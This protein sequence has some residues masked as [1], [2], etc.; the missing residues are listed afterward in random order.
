MKCAEAV[1]QEHQ[2][3]CV[4]RIGWPVGKG[5]QQQAEHS[6]DQQRPN[7]NDEG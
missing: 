6:Q 7:K 4:A 1:E 2:S 5:W 3:Q